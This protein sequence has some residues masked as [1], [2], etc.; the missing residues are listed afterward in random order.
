MATQKIEGLPTNPYDP[1]SASLKYNQGA[2]QIDGHYGQ[3]VWEDGQIV[4][5]D[6]VQHDV[7]PGMMS[8]FK[9]DLQG[10]VISR[11]VTPEGESINFGDV[12]RMGA[13]IAG[14]SSGL[15]SLF[16]GLGLGAA[17]AAGAGVTDA[18]FLAAD[19]AQLAAQGLTESQIA[20]TLGSYGSSAASNLAAS[21]AANGLDVGTITQQLNN[22]G[23]NTGLISQTGSNA[24]FLS[25]DALQL[26]GQV[27][28]NFAAIEQNLIASGVDPLVAADV[29]QQLAFNPG[30]T[31]PQL[32]TN[33][34]NSFGNNIYD[35]N[36]ATTYPT[37][38]LPGSGGL[39]SDVAGVPPTTITPVPSTP[40]A[41]PTTAPAN[42]TGLTTSQIANLVKAGVGL[43][44]AGG[45]ASVAANAGGGNS[46]AVVNP[47][48]GVPTNNPE[49]YNQLQQYY[50]AYLPQTPRDVVSP[51]QQWYNSSYGA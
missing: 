28:N 27:G 8:N 46:G 12:L 38:V 7:T 42:T 49:Y 37:S 41:T 2:Y 25:A 33:L 31:Q 50:N 20:S 18:A 4:G 17:G 16:G 13:T 9:T 51:L 36:M 11:A 14:V 44:G 1:S 30:I 34:S 10:N 5:Y 45:A 43:V 32:A 29:S 19:A 3:P 23:T 22:L 48:Q 39:L 6:F 21:M 15:G 24:D 35:V 26:Q 40:T 47:T